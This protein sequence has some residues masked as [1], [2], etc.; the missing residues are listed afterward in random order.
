[1]LNKSYR[2][3]RHL[4]RGGV[5]GGA[6]H[7]EIGIEMA[8]GAQTGDVRT[9][10]LRHGLWPDEHRHHDRRRHRADAHAGDVGF[11]F[12]VGPL[13]PIPYAAVSTLLAALTLAATSLPA[14]RASRVD[15]VVSPRGEAYAASTPA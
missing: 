14:H 12:G 2:S 3:R 4:R 8:L 5:R 6:A 13:G 10:F 11:L 15:P 9:L 7:L 1:M